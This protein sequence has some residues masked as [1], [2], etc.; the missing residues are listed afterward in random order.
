MTQLPPLLTRAQAA[1]ILCVDPNTVRRW[2]RDG[3]LFAIRMPSGIHK[4]R[5]EDIEA[6][7]NG[8]TPA[9]AA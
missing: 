8:G 4:Y 1:E 7:V 5:R 2:S 9:S 6:I 3:K